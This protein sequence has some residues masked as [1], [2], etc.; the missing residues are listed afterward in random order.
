MKFY[1]YH[2]K[3]TLQKI[4]S[5]DD[6]LFWKQPSFITN[7]VAGRIGQKGISS[8]M[9]QNRRAATEGHQVENIE[10]FQLRNILLPSNYRSTINFP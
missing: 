9:E 8:Y 5:R 7:S 2:L 1:V 10:S 3:Y 6:A 4:E